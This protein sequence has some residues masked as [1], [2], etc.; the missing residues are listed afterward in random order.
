M[1]RGPLTPDNCNQRLKFVLDRMS[2]G[3]FHAAERALRSLSGIAPSSSSSSCLGLFFPPSSFPASAANL[4]S[5]S[6]A[7]Q[8]RDE[9]HRS[10]IERLRKE[11]PDWR[12]EY[13]RMKYR[14]R[15][16]QLAA[17]ASAA[18]EAGRG[19][20]AASARPHTLGQADDLL[21]QNEVELP[22]ERAH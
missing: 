22:G 13:F 1:S 16:A 12:T 20:A 19:A 8:T 11:A 3:S 15:S 4:H 10:V 21:L 17:A 5:T 7:H 18:Q 14:V 2:R 6:A 9:Y